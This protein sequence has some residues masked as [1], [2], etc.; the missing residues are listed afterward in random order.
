MC[1]FRPRAAQQ[2]Q[3]Q[4]EQRKGPA[5]TYSAPRR[6][7]ALGLFAPLRTRTHIDLVTP[8]GNFTQRESV[9]QARITVARP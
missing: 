3:S 5:T 7:C 6:C 9:R 1:R 8:A 4:C 2:I